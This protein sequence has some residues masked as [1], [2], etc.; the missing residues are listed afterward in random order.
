MYGVLT[1]LDKVDD[2]NKQQF[3]TNREE[4]MKALGLHEGRLLCC[5]NY[6]DLTDPHKERL[7]N[8]LPSLD[9]PILEFFV[10]VS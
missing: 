8:I 6:C 2:T 7:R 10:Q 9:L 1:S 5:S 4:F 3:E